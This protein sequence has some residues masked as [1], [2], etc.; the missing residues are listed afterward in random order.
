MY[1]HEVMTALGASR[2]VAIVRANDSETALAQSL[3]I[4]DAGIAVI[5][6]ALTAPGGLEA[7]AELSKQ[8]PDAVVGAGTVLD[9]TTARLAILAGATFLVSP[10]LHADVIRTAHRYG[11]AALPGVGTPTEAITAM[12]EGADAVKL[13]PASA[14]SPSYLRDVRAALPQLPFVPTGGVNADNARAW[15]DAGA[16]AVGLG[17]FLTKGEPGD[18]TAVK[19]VLEAIG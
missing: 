14:L 3:S 8:R 4:V 15:L 5:E 12:E 9:A 17:S 13:F 6:I 19:S 11:A 7:I 1:R 16:L 2:A 10:S 18:T